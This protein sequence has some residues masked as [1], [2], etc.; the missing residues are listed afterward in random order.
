M[1]SLADVRPIE[2][3]AGSGTGTVGETVKITN[4]YQE[5]SQL[6]GDISLVEEIGGGA[7]DVHLGNRTMSVRQYLS[8]LGFNGADQQKM[9]SEL[10][11]GDWNRCNLAR[12]EQHTTELQSQP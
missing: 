1:S 4:V 10:S 8:R 5:R 12:S 3:T 6:A 7:E 11:G 2:G 9:A